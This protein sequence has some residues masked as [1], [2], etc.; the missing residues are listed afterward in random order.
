MIR[1]NNTLLQANLKDINTLLPQ[2]SS[3][4]VLELR[5]NRKQ[6]LLLTKLQLLEQKKTAKSHNIE[7]CVKYRQMLESWRVEAKDT[8]QRLKLE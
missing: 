5:I 8:M 2:S 6:V 7:N 1:G 3:Y 4:R